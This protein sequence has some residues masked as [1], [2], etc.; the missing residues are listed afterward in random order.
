MINQLFSLIQRPERG[1]DPVPADHARGYAEEQWRTDTAPLADRLEQRV[2]SFRGRS[3]LDLGA[4]PGSY[5]LEF[6][7][8]GANVTWF[9]V[10]RTYR[11]LARERIAAQ[12]AAV[13]FHLGYLEQARE[14]GRRFDL[15]FSRIC[16]Y[17]SM[18]DRAFARILHGLVAPGGWAYVVTP[19][20][21]GWT[22]AAATHRLRS[23]LN[24]LTGLKVG[25]PFPTRALF[26]RV[27]AGLEMSEVEI[28]TP[29]RNVSILFRR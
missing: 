11:E 24:D 3:V 9:D 17:Y 1:W 18:S 5:T 12:G 7:K 23:K 14:L 21:E 25:H 10:S 4:G 13:E 22:D 15:V 16:W 28:D 27:W 19:C 2:G 8:R 6:A 26:R 29:G 20:I